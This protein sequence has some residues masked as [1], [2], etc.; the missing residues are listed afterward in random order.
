MLGEL[1]AAFGS[2]KALADLVVAGKG[3]IDQAKFT[4]ALFDLNDCPNKHP[5]LVFYDYMPLIGTVV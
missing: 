3:L 1:T 2:A 5:Q 4:S